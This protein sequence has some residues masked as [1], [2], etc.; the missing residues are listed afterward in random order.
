[1]THSLLAEGG[2]S[3]IYGAKEVSTSSGR[4]REFAAKKVLAQD[5]ETREIAE[6]EAALLTELASHPACVRCHGVLERA[7]PSGA[8]GVR[9]FWMLLEMC[10]NGSL[11][12]LIYVKKPS[13]EYE[14]GPPLPQ[15]RV[16]PVFAQLARAVAHL[17]GLSPAV[18][19]RDIKL[20]NVICRADGEYVLCDFG[21]A[22]RR[23]LPR[24]RT[25]AAAAM[26]EERIQKYRRRPLLSGLG[27]ALTLDGGRCSLR[28]GTRRTCTARPRWSTSSSTRRWDRKST[29]GRWAAYDGGRFFILRRRGEARPARDTC[30]VLY[31]LCF[32]DHPF[33][34]ESNIAILNGN[35]SIP[36][37]SPY[38]ENVHRAQNPLSN[39]GEC[40][41]RRRSLF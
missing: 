21:S 41:L 5:G 24:K 19:H 39:L 11:I 38:S 37:G 7:A 23:T 28:A 18:A 15:E 33:P 22:T 4:A 17:H 25:R 36:L 40:Y 1:M 6:T 13:G 9:E 2:Y 29:S 32:R 8:P 12:D 30:Q 31:A 20:E 27:A 14:R 3:F 16:L 10:P 26:E 35:F 34:P